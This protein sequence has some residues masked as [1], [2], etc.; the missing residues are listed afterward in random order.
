MLRVFQLRK[1]LGCMSQGTMSITSYLTKFRTL[2]AEIDNLNHMPKCTCVTRN[3]TC[4]NAQKI[5]KYEE[6]I[7]LSKFLMGLHDQ[8]TAGR[9]QLLMMQ[10]TITQAFSLL[11]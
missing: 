8:Y 9:G 4:H 1:E 10:P 6:M 7:K 3:C 5:E 11:L 2:L